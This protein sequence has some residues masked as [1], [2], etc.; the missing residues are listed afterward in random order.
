MLLINQL[1]QAFIFLI[2]AVHAGSRVP[3]KA[4][5]QPA[6]YNQ[7]QSVSRPNFEAFEKKQLGLN[8]FIPSAP[9]K[10]L[11]IV[12]YNVHYFT[13]LFAKGCNVSNV[14]NDVRIMDAGVILFQEVLT[15]TSNQYRKD[16]DAGLDRLGYV[17]RYFE[18]ASGAFLG[19]M[20]ASRY[21]LQN[22]GVLDL[23]YARVMLE[24]DVQLVG[25]DK[26][27]LFGTHWENADANAR[28]KQAQI[29]MKHFNAKGAMGNFVLGA[30]FNAHYRSPAIQTLVNSGLMRSSFS[31]LKWPYPNYTCWAG[32]P[33]DFL[34]IGSAAQKNVLGSYVYHTLSSDHLPIIVDLDLE[35]ANGGKSA[36]Q[37]GVTTTTSSNFGFYLLLILSVLGV[38][39][40][41]FAIVVVIRRRNARNTGTEQQH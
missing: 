6:S 1:F 24:A 31:V 3:G 21:P 33:I 36:A 37:K 38:A 12:T 16:F 8:K 11:R 32:H 13:D 15:S 2:T 41:A 34:F 14:L 40:A 22:L 25:G 18:A 39:G 35:P 9:S 27:T 30:D 10:G 28:L 29:T 19:N 4:Q 26:I 20:I 23:G 5:P 17:Y 7:H